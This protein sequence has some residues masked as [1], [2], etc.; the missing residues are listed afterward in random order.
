MEHSHLSH[1]LQV[2]WM[3][4]TRKKNFEVIRR[5]LLKYT[6]GDFKIFQ[7]L[8]QIFTVFWTSVLL[9]NLSLS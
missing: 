1:T 9:Q 8:L 4:I 3:N 5:K 7:I 2:K 6:K